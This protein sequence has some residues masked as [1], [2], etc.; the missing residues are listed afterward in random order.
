MLA[1]LSL[2]GKNRSGK[3]TYSGRWT[4]KSLSHEEA[5]YSLQL[6]PEMQVA[7]EEARGR[8]P[9]SAGTILSRLGELRIL[10]CK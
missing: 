8:V 7:G 2:R 1:N 10:V 5:R 6:E 3:W 9:N 4:R